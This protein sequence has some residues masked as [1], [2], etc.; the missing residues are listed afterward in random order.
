MLLLIKIEK[1]NHPQLTEIDREPN[2]AALM[3]PFD[4]NLTKKCLLRYTHTTIRKSM[5]DWLGQVIYGKDN[6]L[7]EV[8]EKISPTH[9][10]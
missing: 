10:F 9:I 8:L 2:E 6:F 4:P 5:Y 3:I 7:V 1:K